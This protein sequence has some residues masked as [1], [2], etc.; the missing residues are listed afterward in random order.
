MS[1]VNFLPEGAS[2]SCEGLAGANEGRLYRKAYRE[3]RAV[4]RTCAKSLAG[5]NNGRRLY[6]KAYREQRAMR[7]AR[8]KVLQVPTSDDL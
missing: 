2:R 1:R 8:A 7:R 3:Q 5:A 6:R 4:R